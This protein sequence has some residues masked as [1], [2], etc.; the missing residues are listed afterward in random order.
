M[1]NTGQSCGANTAW[2]S[3]P[4]TTKRLLLR[5]AAEATAVGNPEEEGEHISPLFDQIQFDRVQNMIQVRVSM[6]GPVVAGSPGRPDGFG[7]AFAHI[8]ADVN[9]SM[10][11]AREKS[12]VTSSRCCL[13][14]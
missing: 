5:G 2:W 7:R 13:R 8:F 10:R 4:V 6:R 12:L 14:Y 11:I 1:F 3:G 9:N